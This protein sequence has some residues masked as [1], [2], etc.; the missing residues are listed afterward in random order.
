M[1]G[2]WYHIIRPFPAESDGKSIMEEWNEKG[3]SKITYAAGDLHLCLCIEAHLVRRA[4]NYWSN[5]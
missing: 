4:C 1:E 5:S 3:S 2:V